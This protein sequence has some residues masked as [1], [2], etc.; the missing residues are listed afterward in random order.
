MSDINQKIKEQLASHKIVLYM[1]GDTRFPMCGF[2]AQVIKILKLC[3]VNDFL[4]V[5]VLEDQEIRQAIKQYSN[6]P[7]IP[8]LYINQVLIGG[9][10]IISEMYENGELQQ[11]LLNS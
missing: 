11:L 5:N 9:A 10:D 1:K 3:G 7:T 2:S 4:T 8:Q 6:W